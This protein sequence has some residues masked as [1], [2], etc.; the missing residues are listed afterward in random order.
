[1]K[2]KTALL[3]LLVAE[4]SFSCI[5]TANAAAIKDDGKYTL[6]LTCGRNGLDGKIDGDYSKMI[7]FDV[8]EGDTM[9]SELD[10]ITTRA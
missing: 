10:K 2:L 9:V 5:M 4:L 1:M 7:R 6:L 8:A 3:M